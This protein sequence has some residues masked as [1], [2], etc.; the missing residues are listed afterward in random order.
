ML[1]DSQIQLC[2]YG[3][4]ICLAMFGASIWKL[5][6]S[7]FKLFVRQCC[8]FHLFLLEINPSIFW[9][10]IVICTCSCKF[11]MLKVLQNLF[12]L[13]HAVCS[14]IFYR[15][16]ILPFFGI[17]ALLLRW[18]IFFVHV[19]IICKSDWTAKLVLTR[20]VPLFMQ[21]EKME[22]SFTGSSEEVLD[23]VFCQK[24][25]RSFKWVPFYLILLRFF[26]KMKWDSLN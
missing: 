18:N 4:V 16:H 19:N 10:Y 5:G 8:T 21:V 6:S 1:S 3:C 25:V 13:I 11:I 15:N 2:I 14:I 26:S 12:L 24:T 22:K 23:K 9:N 17:T 20:T 7:W